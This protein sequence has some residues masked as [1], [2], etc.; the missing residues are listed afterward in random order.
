MPDPVG[1]DPA[2]PLPPVDPDDKEDEDNDNDN[3]PPHTNE[4]AE[5]VPIIDSIKG[6]LAV[7]NE[8]ESDDSSD[9]M[10]LE[11]PP[12]K[13]E[14]FKAT[15]AAGHPVANS[16]DSKRCISIRKITEKYP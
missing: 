1:P 3:G 15:E 8:C 13:G 12:T 5:H 9:T 6:S 11:P 10:S 2:G 4:N 7:I 16:N 14:Q